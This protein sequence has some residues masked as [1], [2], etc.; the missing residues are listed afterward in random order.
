[1]ARVAG[2]SLPADLLDDDVSYV[3]GMGL[4]RVA[5]G[6]LQIANPI[7]REVIPRA[8]TWTQQIRMHQPTEWYVRPDRALDIPKLMTAWQAF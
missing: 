7:Y 8:L 3:L 6:E 1:L 2:T 4:V 5:R